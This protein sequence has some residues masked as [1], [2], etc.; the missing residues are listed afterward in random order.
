MNYMLSLRDKV[1]E[2]K[3]QGK[4]SISTEEYNECKKEYLRLLSI[5]K[6]E[7]M[8]DFIKS[9]GD[10]YKTEIQLIQR[11]IEYVDDHL[12]FLT[13]FRIDFTN[14]LAERWLRKIKMKLKMAG[15]FR[16]LKSAKCYC[17]AISVI[18][19]CKKQNKNIFKALKDIMSGKKKYLNLPIIKSLHFSESSLFF[20]KT[21][22][23]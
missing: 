9:P 22:I 8:Q 11:L 14:N 3:N 12:R 21:I 5:W 4:S 2:Y 13:D 19:T 18:D 10:F 1:D 17:H 20:S 23:L 6:E 16:T 7:F 15:G